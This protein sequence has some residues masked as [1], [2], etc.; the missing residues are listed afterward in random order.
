MT[1]LGLCIA[2][3]QQKHDVE[4]RVMA[5]EIGISASTLSRIKSGKMPDAVG[6]VKIWAWLVE[7]NKNL[8]PL[9]KREN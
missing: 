7:E 3:Y 9:S 8:Q 6:M 2:A 5:R 1:N 4:N